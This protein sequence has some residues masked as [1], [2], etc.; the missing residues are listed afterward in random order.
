MSRSLTPLT[1]GKRAVA[2]QA[3]GPVAARPTVVQLTNPPLDYAYD[4]S[5][6]GLLTVL[7]AI[8]E[9]KSAPNSIQPLGAVQGGLFA[10]PVQIDTHEATA[11]RVWEGLLRHMNEEARTRLFHTFLS[12]QPDRE[13]LIFRYADLAMRAGR[14]ISDNY[15]DEN[16]RRVAG[17]AQQMYREKHRMEAFV[18]FE[19]TSDGLFHATID[20][21]FDV[22]PLIA[23]HFTKRYADQRWLIFDRRRR[24]GLYYDLHRTDVVQFETNAPQRTTDISAT[25]LDEREP[26]FKLLWQS[27]FDHV[28]IPERKNLKLHRRHM[29]L[30]YWRYLSEKQ[31]R[32]Q[33]FEPIK[34]KRPVQPGGPALEAGPDALPE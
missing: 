29:P 1:S 27:Y 20:P 31:P 8:Y 25:V 18:R 32:E 2:S 28:N 19:K 15:A 30:R 12:E 16:V 22:L 26:L 24:Y 5:F 23:P 34:N 4:G 3:T 13:L 9:R 21:D 6:E 7:F 17:I 11:A 14:D 33:R 10:Q